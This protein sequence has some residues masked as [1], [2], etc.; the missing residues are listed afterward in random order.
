MSQSA[1]R[2]L[3]VTEGEYRDQI[4]KSKESPL[5]AFFADFHVQYQ[6]L[7]I[8][9]K[10]PIQG[11]GRADN[12]SH[13]RLIYAQLKKRD[14]PQP[15]APSLNFTGTYPAS[16]TA[17]RGTTGDNKAAYRI[18]KETGRITFDARITSFPA[19]AHI[20]Y[21]KLVD[22][23]YS[24][25]SKLTDIEKASFELATWNFKF[26]KEGCTGEPVWQINP[27]EDPHPEINV[28]FSSCRPR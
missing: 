4:L 23:N 25:Y 21:K 26:R 22:D 27:Y 18:V 9:L 7:L 17:V 14:L 1:E 10:A 3:T 28:E 2:D 19:G 12:V 20:F 6:T 24:D 8:Q 13:V 5:P 16:V 11:V 15:N